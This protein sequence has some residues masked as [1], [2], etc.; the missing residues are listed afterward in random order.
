MDQV[1]QN[2]DLYRDRLDTMLNS[3]QTYFPKETQYSLPKGG[4]F[5]WVELPEHL[6]ARILLE[7]TLKKGVAFVPGS[8]FYPNGGGNN[9]L[10]LNFTNTDSYKI[11]KGIRV[12]GEEIQAM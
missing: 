2:I 1:E 10:R 11:T 4:M 6:D 7:Q 5:V 8:A 3:I 12:I 9:T